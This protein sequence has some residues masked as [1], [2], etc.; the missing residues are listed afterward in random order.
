ILPGMVAGQNLGILATSPLEAIAKSFAL[1]IILATVLALATLSLGLSVSAWTAAMLAWN[2]GWALALMFR[3]RTL[4]PD[5]LLGVTIRGILAPRQWADAG[6]LLAIGGLSILCYRWGDRLDN[7]DWE[8]GLQLIY[9]R[10]YASS[11]PLDFSLTALRPEIGVPNLFFAW[12]FLLGGISHAAGVDPLVGA[13]R[14]R[15]LIPVLG[16]SSFF[17]FARHVLGGTMAA[18]RAVWVLLALVL[19]QFVALAPS[20]FAT[21]KILTG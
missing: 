14:S 13:L 10:N 19:T 16:F 18:R 11:L 6:L 7:V 5:G 4:R 8:V 15:W 1:S 3:R 17:F 9:V 12:E 2:A 21:F 20:P